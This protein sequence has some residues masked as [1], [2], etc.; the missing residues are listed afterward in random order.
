MNCCH[1]HATV[2]GNLEFVGQGVANLVEWSGGEKIVWNFI[3]TTHINHPTVRP[4]ASQI[5]TEV[6]MSIIHGSMGIMY[7]VHEWEPS[8]RE[9]GI[10]RYPNVVQGVREIN[11]QVASL[12]PVLNSPTVEEGADVEAAVPI[13]RMVKE[14]D[15]STYLFAV[16]MRNQAAPATFTL[17]AMQGGQVEV[18]GEDRMLAFSDG[19]FQDNFSGY[20]VH[21]YKISP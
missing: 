3:E 15:G 8:F 1:S 5:K 11:A 13:A 18:I 7:F 9:D 19:R 17:P 10:F 12:A 21:L 2:H 20:G 16:A 4:T 6:W 14:Y